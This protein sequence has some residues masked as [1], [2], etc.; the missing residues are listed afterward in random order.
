MRLRQQYSLIFY[1]G[2]LFQ[3]IG[4][5]TL[6]SLEVIRIS[7]LCNSPLAKLQ[8]KFQTELM[9]AHDQWLRATTKALVHMKIPKLHAWEECFKEG[10]EK[11]RKLEFKWTFAVQFRKA[12]NS[13][14]SSHLPFWFQLEL[15]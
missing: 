5:A 10:I 14:C 1:L 13:S 9:S 4:W 8:H 11:L 3:E 15:L 2:I 12:Y 7:M 6:S